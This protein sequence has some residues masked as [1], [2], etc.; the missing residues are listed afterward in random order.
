MVWMYIYLCLALDIC[1]FYLWIIYRDCVN[2]KCTQIPVI[3]DIILH[4]L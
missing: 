2:L 3:L 4:S 1:V